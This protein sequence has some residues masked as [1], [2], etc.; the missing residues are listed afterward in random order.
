MTKFQDIFSY[1]ILISEGLSAVTA[2]LF[3]KKV[4]EKYW[5][6]FAVYLLVIFLCECFGKWG[7]EWVQYNKTSF[8]NYFV[9]PLQ[10]LFFFWLYA[11][12]SLNRPRLFYLFTLIYALSFFPYEI[13]FK[14]SKIIFS[15]NYTLGCL[16]L[17]ILVIMEFYKQITS[18]NILLFKSNIMFYI[19]IGVTLFYIGTLPLFSFY[20]LIYQ[21][22]DFWE[23]YFNYF[24]ISCV[25]MYLLFSISFIWG[26]QNYT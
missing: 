7:H 19:N 9:I 23:I 25:I 24:L 21:Y 13:F 12:K 1:L 22:P 4:R 20:F 10:F 26:K 2:F 15:F 6:W 5:I 16:L 18:P 8:Y 17:L 14:T 11:Y 3:Y